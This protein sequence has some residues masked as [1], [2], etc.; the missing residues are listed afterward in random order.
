MIVPVPGL[1]VPASLQPQ[2][3]D[4][5]T[6]VSLEVFQT[7]EMFPQ[8]PRVDIKVVVHEYVSESRHSPDP[9]GEPFGDHT[10]FREYVDDISVSVGLPELP[11]R[12]DVA[13][14][15]QHRLDGYL[16]QS[17]RGCP[18]RTFCQEYVLRELPDPLEIGNA[19]LDPADA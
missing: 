17:F 4:Y 1:T 2:V 15:V 10:L 14:Y 12:D 7:A 5:V 3:F 8:F 11:L 13:A 9:G 6:G 16:E 19:F 18:D